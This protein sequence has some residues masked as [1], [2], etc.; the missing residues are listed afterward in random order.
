MY[1]KSFMK[2][3]VAFFLIFVFVSIT[4]NAQIQT[5][6]TN[7]VKVKDI[8]LAT[9]AEIDTLCGKIAEKFLIISNNN[10]SEIYSTIQD[11]FNDYIQN[12]ENEEANIY[13]KVLKK[14]HLTVQFLNY[15]NSY[16]WIGKGVDSVSNTSRLTALILIPAF[17]NIHKVQ[18][19]NTI[20]FKAV[21]ETIS[22]TNLISQKDF[23]YSEKF[24]ELKRINF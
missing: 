24:V 15:E 19:V 17:D 16:G 2:L 3:K 10:K 12:S 6:L 8:A 14:K 18:I 4:M 11:F 5:N 20:C 7:F 22:K 21:F 13:P 23:M 9:N 1:K